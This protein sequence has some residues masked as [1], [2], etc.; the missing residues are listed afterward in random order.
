[1]VLILNIIV[2]LWR[3]IKESSVPIELV[4]NMEE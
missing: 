1:M 3:L 2:Y 4:K